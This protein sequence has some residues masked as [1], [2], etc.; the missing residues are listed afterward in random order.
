MAILDK[1]VPI[2]KRINNVIYGDMCAATYL[3]CR[4]NGIK[5]TIDKI[6][7]SKQ[8]KWWSKNA[9]KKVMEEYESTL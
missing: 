5:A 7:K 2:K 1:T 9:T 3:F 6:N 8:L 4:E